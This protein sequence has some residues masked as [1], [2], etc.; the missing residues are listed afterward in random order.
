MS[1]STWH[2]ITHSPS[3]GC[4]FRNMVLPRFVS[5]WQEMFEKTY[6]WFDCL[7]IIQWILL[8]DGCFINTLQRILLHHSYRLHI[9]QLSRPR[10]SRWRFLLLWRCLTVVLSRPRSSS[11]PSRSSS[12]HGV[13][14]TSFVPTFVVRWPTLLPPSCRRADDLFRPR[15]HRRPSSAA[16][17]RYVSSTLT[18][19]S[20]TLIPINNINLALVGTHYSIRT[21]IFSLS[22]A[23]H[24]QFSRSQSLHAGK[25]IR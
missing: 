2:F 21:V 10:T 9:R 23:Q 4:L 3:S 20:D 5:M 11:W 14:S 22:E 8:H 15:P 7:E 18:N 17:P 12:C 1:Y 19:M 24:S 25:S 6:V 16:Q 13:A